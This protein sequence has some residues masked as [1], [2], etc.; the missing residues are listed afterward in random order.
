MVVILVLVIELF[1]LFC[2]L[3]KLIIE[4]RMENK[5]LSRIITA[6]PI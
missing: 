4:R 2:M 5:S 3:E 1:Q 6:K